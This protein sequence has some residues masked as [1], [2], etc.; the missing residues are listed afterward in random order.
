LSQQPALDPTRLVFIDETWAKT[1][2]TST[3]GRCRR[4]KRLIARVPFGHWKT[5]TF[6]AALRCD[7]IT[8]PAVM[9]GP[10]NGRSFTAYVEQFLVPTLK[11]GDIVVLDNLGSHKGK[12]AR[13][14]IERAGAELRFLPPYSPDL[15]PIE[16]VF[17]KLKTL[18]RKEAPRTRET[19][20]K[21]IGSLLDRFSAA[22]CQNYLANAGCR[23]PN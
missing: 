11:P 1:N 10:I 12:Q 17:A 6:L 13:A 8:A 23:A 7:T 16:Q 9:D 20:W 14:A 2:M 4:G 22:E 18:L 15:N 3:H 19:L 5:S 21:Q